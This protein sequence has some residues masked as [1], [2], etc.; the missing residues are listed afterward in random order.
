MSQFLTSKHNSSRNV[1]GKKKTETGP[2]SRE[3]DF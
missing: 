2:L 1:R 3:E